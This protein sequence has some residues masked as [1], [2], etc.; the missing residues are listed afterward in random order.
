M[1]AL[2]PDVSPRRQC[3]GAAKQLKRIKRQMLCMP[4]ELS[5]NGNSRELAVA[6]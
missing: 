6:G 3:A 1:S 2:D 5:G 4:N